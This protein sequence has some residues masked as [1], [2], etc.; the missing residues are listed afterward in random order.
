MKRTKEQHELIDK[1]VNA[2]TEMLI[3]ILQTTSS[4]HA[5]IIEINPKFIK[6][7]IPWFSQQLKEK[8]KYKNE[9]LEDY[10]SHKLLSYKT[11]LKRICNE[12][13]SLKRSLKKKYI[14]L[15]IEKVNFD[16]KK[17]WSLLKSLTNR[18][19]SKELK[20]PEMMNQEKA[21]KY[22][23]YFATIGTE[24]Q[25]Q[26]GIDMQRP[27]YARSV[28]SNSQKI[29]N[30]TLFKFSEEK[31]STIEKLIDKLK[32][33]TATGIDN[34][35]PQLIKDAKY[36]ITPTLTKIINKCYKNNIFPHCMKIASIKPIYKKDD[37]NKISNYRP[38][39]IL[40]TLSKV[41]ERS[42]VDQIISYLE[43]HQ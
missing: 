37:P 26:L 38:I 9:L 20:E 24:I 2:A 18:H 1:D 4:R 27:T 31:E 30:H 28:F 12:I 23:R 43:E 33:D 6:K 32:T 42:A 5:P 3:K 17:L 10:F 25:K 34:I 41:F 7:K 16:S 40:P 35:G 21:D 13:T 11:R 8:I 29:N 14:T 15:Q 36:T 22:N 19:K 39:S